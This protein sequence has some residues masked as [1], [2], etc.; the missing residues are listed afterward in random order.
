[1]QTLRD[2]HPLYL[3][4]AILCAMLVLILAVAPGVRPLVAGGFGLLG[5]ALLS[6]WGVVGRL[7]APR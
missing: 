7:P 3:V 4:Y 2:S 6:I 1:M 5:L